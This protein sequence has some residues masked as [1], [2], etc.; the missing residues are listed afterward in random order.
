MTHSSSIPEWQNTINTPSPVFFPSS[1]PTPKLSSTPTKKPPSPVDWHEE[2]VR[3][4]SNS[5]AR[6][7]AR[8]RRNND[9]HH[10]QPS[11]TFDGD[12]TRPDLDL[13]LEKLQ[14]ST[15]STDT[16][17]SS[18]IGDLDDDIPADD[19]FAV[20]SLAAATTTNGP[21]A[22]TAL[23]AAT[24]TDGTTT[25]FSSD[26]QH[27]TNPT[28]LYINPHL[29]KQIQH[30]SDSQQLRQW[31]EQ[32]P[33]FSSELPS[34]ATAASTPQE[35]KRASLVNFGK[36]WVT[37]MKKAASNGTNNISN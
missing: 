31:L 33:D 36:Q 29:E 21:A 1:S 9:L 35:M 30:E 12:L 27:T 13:L 22:N 18:F 14:Q 25:H 5:A 8:A 34:G 28:P 24:T 4:E 19:L 15:L 7:T 3:D 32:L 20:L 26:D 11:F 2:L 23:A 37:R 6:E 16:M 10:H 17:T